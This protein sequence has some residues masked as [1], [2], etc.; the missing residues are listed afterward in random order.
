MLA[1]A[2][3][4]F[5]MLIT[6]GPG[7]LSAAGV[8]AG[9]GLRPGARYIAGLWV[10][11]L[12]VSLLVVSGIWALVATI[13]WLRLLLGGASLAYLLYLATKIAF[14]GAKISFGKVQ[15][16]PSFSN[17]LTLQFINPK[18]YAVYTF[19]FA[20]FAFFP[21]NYEAEVVSKLLIINAIWIP[22]HIA[23]L[24]AGVLIRSLELSPRSQ[25]RINILMATSM[26]LVVLLAALG[27]R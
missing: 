25:R 10:G 27:L 3:A 7:V 23:W 16:A 5:F 12:C 19:F 22:I 9:F 18:A 20:N 15:N 1:F 21:T 26:V 14:A 24:Y 6:P 4:V 13:P 8:G 17:G 11:N 2:A